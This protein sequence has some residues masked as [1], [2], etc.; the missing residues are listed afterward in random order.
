MARAP[1][2][3]LFLALLDAVAPFS[4]IAPTLKLSRPRNRVR[5]ESDPL[6]R[7]GKIAA[8]RAKDVKFSG[9]I[10]PAFS[11]AVVGGVLLGPLGLLGGLAMG[12]AAKER[13]DAE[14][15]L[16]KLGLDKE[17]VVEVSKDL[18]KDIHLLISISITI[19]VSA[20]ASPTQ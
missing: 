7:L 10:N 9:G 15:E 6:G 17:F 1:L 18:S 12:A 13:Q 8:N 4:A 2:L 11:G 20:V 14:N 5:I 16:K 3:V 19:I